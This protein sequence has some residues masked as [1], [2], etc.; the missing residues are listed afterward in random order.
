MGKHY[1]AIWAKRIMLA[2]AVVFATGFGYDHYTQEEYAR[3]PIMAGAAA[4]AIYLAVGLVFGL[5]NLV[6][7]FL[8]LWLFQEADMVRSIV[9]DLHAQKL[10]APTRWQSKN[11]DYLRQLVD[12]DDAAV[13]ARLRAAILLGSF[14][15]IMANGFFRSITIRGALDKAFLRY[16]MEAPEREPN[17]QDDE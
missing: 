5:I 11:Y 4:I 15:A 8:Y 3:S 10:P 16:S 17:R 12:D 9:A 1:W 6:S 13:D 14:D 7:G 2:L